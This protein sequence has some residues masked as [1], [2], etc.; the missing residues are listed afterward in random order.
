MDLKHL[1]TF[2]T[3]AEAR[4]ESKASQLLHISQSALS[5]QVSNLEQEFGLKLFERSGGALY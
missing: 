4:T 1:R 2:V 3:V 5:R